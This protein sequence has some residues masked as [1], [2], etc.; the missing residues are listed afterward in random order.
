[1][2]LKQEY[3]YLFILFIFSDELFLKQSRSEETSP[4]KAIKQLK[5][6]DLIC[7]FLYLAYRIKCGGSGER[8]RA[9]NICKPEMSFFGVVCCNTPFEYGDAHIFHFASWQTD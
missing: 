3:Y 1:M 6:N 2:G 8:K 4:Y 7:F 5:T 9:R